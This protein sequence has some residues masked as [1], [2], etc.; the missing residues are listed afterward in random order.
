MF[1]ILKYLVDLNQPL[2][3]PSLHCKY[4]SLAYIVEIVDDM[5]ATID[6]IHMHGRHTFSNFTFMFCSYLN[7]SMKLGFIRIFF[8]GNPHIEAS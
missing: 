8:G 4:N 2:N 1:Y 7:A 6:H 5:N 3:S